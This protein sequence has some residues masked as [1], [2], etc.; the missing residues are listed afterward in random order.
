LEHE[1][2]AQLRV[3]PCSTV[4]ESRY[5]EGDELFVLEQI[6]SGAVVGDI[7][8]R[9][10]V[11]QCSEDVEGNFI[12]KFCLRDGREKFENFCSTEL[13]CFSDEINERC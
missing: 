4:V 10:R 5:D 13:P 9:E 11:E 3:L 1:R 6:L 8:D 2:S 7:I 12:F